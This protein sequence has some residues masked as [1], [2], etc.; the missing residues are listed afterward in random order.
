MLFKKN[1]ARKGFDSSNFFSYNFEKNLY[2]IE[3]KYL[4]S[5]EGWR[6]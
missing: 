2:Y 6:G 3:I 4:S 1:V 5:L